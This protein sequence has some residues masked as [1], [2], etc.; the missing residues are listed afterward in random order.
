M[1]VQYVHLECLNSMHVYRCLFRL[2][3][4][5]SM[6]GWFDTYHYST[7]TVYQYTLIQY[8]Y[9]CSNYMTNVNVSS[10]LVIT[11]TQGSDRNQ[12]KQLHN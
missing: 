5:E 3:E 10:S 1:Y 11:A 2:G 8:I 7:C 6:V 12:H 9:Q 4:S